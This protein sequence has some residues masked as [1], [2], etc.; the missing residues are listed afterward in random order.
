MDD[1]RLLGIETAIVTDL[2]AQIQFRKMVYFGL[3]HYFDYI[4]TSEEAGCDKPDPAPFILDLEKMQLQPNEIRMIGDNPFNDIQGAKKALGAFTLQKLHEG[5]VPGLDE[6][7]PDILFYDYSSLRK[8]IGKI[9]Y[10]EE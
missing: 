7:E 2:T 3:D 5:V 10:N 4:V 1:L 6:S 9:A 8:L